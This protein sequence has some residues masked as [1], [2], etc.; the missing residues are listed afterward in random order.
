MSTGPPNEWRRHCTTV[1]AENECEG[2]VEEVCV[3]RCRRQGGEDAASRAGNRGGSCCPR[4]PA[5]HVGRTCRR[6]LASELFI[7]LCLQVPE[8]N[9]MV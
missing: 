3:C 4:S 5:V 7:G 8:L 9:L 1:A 2:P 6:N